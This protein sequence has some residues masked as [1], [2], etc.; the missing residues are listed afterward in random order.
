MASDIDVELEG[1]TYP[2]ASTFALGPADSGENGHDVDYEA[3]PGAGPVLSGAERLTGWQPVAG[4][5]STW[6]VSLPSGFDTAQLYVNGVS[7]PMA[8]GLPASTEFIQTSFGFITTAAT[9][10]SWHDPSDISAVFV[11]GNGAWTETSCP[12]ASISGNDVVMAEPCWDNLHLPGQGLQEVSWVYGPQGGFGGLSP[13][14]QPTYLENAVELLTP[15]SWVIDRVSHQLFFMAP[16]GMD[17]TS[18]DFE[19]P[20]L[21]T[22]A[23]VSGTLSDPVHDIVVRGITFAYGTWTGTDTDDGFAQMQADWR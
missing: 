12:I 20:T 11:G 1:G 4:S 13:L 21:Q 19:V 2:L 17:V 22:L 9:M 16:A 14:A 15:G 3:A 5:P 6:V 23:S 10:D 7:A 8:Q 18:A